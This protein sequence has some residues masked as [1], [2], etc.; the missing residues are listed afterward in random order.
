MTLGR[1]LHLGGNVLTCEADVTHGT[2]CHEDDKAGAGGC[3][4]QRRP[5]SKPAQSN[6]HGQ[7]S[8]RVKWDTEDTTP[9]PPP[10]G[11]P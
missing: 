11:T 4:A 2:H 10:P 6:Q 8:G 3:C 7:V 9:P 1:G 5:Q